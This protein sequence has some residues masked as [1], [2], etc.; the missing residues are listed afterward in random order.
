MKRYEKITLSRVSNP[1]LQNHILVLVFGFSI[2]GHK[3][4]EYYAIV[5]IVFHLNLR[6]PVLPSE[7][8]KE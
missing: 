4:E 6:C 2:A 1:L 8:A 7:K 5:V 3:Y